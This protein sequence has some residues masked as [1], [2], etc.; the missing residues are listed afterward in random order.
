MRPSALLLVAAG[1]LWTAATLDCGGCPPGPRGADASGADAAAPDAGG[2]AGADAG[3]DAGPVVL[4]FSQ[5]CVAYA[6]QLCAWLVTCN[7]W[8]DGAQS[9]CASYYSH[10]LCD[11][12][13]G[14]SIA[15]GYLAYDPVAG[16]DCLVALQNP[17]RCDP[18]ATIACSLAVRGD[19]GAGQPCLTQLDCQDVTNLCSGSP[20]A[21]TCQSTGGLNQ[22]CGLS[23]CNAGTWCDSGGVCRAPQPP[24]SPCDGLQA[25]ECDA[26][27]ECD[28]SQSL[29]VALPSA[30][31]AC[32]AG[33]TPCAA[34]YYCAGGQ[35]QPD[36][37]AGQPCSTSVPCEPGTWC[38]T[39]QPSP[40]CQPAVADGGVCSAASLCSSG[41]VCRSGECLPPSGR[42]GS[43]ASSSDCQVGL[44][45]DPVLGSCELTIPSA[46]GEPCTGF[47]RNCVGQTTCQGAI[48][49]DGGA[50]R[51]GTCVATAIGSACSS[52]FDCPTASAC[53]RPDG[54]VAG[55]CVA[56][57]AGS[58][59]A[60]DLNCPSGDY[61]TASGTCASRLAAGAPCT[62]VSFEECATPDI[63]RLVPDAGTACASP[64]IIGVSCLSAASCL[65]PLICSASVCTLAGELGLPCSSGSPACFA[66][67]CDRD[68]GT[69]GPPLPNGQPCRSPVECVSGHCISGV[70]AAPCP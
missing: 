41:L 32:A 28:T 36:A 62:G 43:C 61:C 20:C 63:C 51:L 18:A 52:G 34:G 27:S 4:T 19:S 25:S 11:A 29:C 7:Q 9:D 13:W 65:P 46:P 31:Q 35:C 55:T 69:C 50:G 10:A 3:V 23:G 5:F 16:A 67:A 22:P 53:V 70:C 33:P 1:A 66:G 6:T 59:C 17:A 8:F 12:T 44:D 15:K 60:G 42:G 39:T 64:G 38:D 26:T 48:L 2:D 68:A 56:S 37:P 57:S 24:G 21:M 14:D 45:C 49:A 40:I 54:G 58:P 47:T 30:G